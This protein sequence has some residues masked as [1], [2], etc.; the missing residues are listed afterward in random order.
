M[1]V[2]DNDFLVSHSWFCFTQK[3][4]SSLFT[5]QSFKCTE[6]EIADL[7]AIINIFVHGAKLAN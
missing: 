6:T 4:I 5:I 1:W 2:Q 3:I 7:E